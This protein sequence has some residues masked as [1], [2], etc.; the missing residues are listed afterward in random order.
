MSTI[1]QEGKDIQQQFD[2]LFSKEEN[3]FVDQVYLAVSTSGRQ[4]SS[5]ETSI[6]KLNTNSTKFKSEQRQ[7]PLNQL[8][9][10][11]GIF[12][13]NT[14]KF[15]LFIKDHQFSCDEET[16]VCNYEQVDGLEWSIHQNFLAMSGW[17]HNMSDKHTVYKYV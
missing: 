9:S 11:P 15:S 13:L 2:N 17:N 10:I 1:F 6:F 16:E 8:I 4:N 5:F 7:I 14:S 12:L 3:V